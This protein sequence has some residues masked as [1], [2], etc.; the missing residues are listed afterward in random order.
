METAQREKTVVIRIGSSQPHF[1]YGNKYVQ[2]KP[3]AKDVPHQKNLSAYPGKIYVG[4]SSMTKG[5]YETGDKHRGAIAS[6]NA[7]DVYRMEDYGKV[8]IDDDTDVLFER[9]AP[10]RD[11]QGS[12]SDRIRAQ[13]LAKTVGGPGNNMWSACITAAVADGHG[14]L[15]CLGNQWFVGGFES[16]RIAAS[17]AAD[18]MSRFF[19]MEPTKQDKNGRYSEPMSIMSATLF[20]YLSNGKTPM[21]EMRKGMCDSIVNV[22]AKIF[23]E[24]DERIH[25]AWASKSGDLNID[26][27]F[28]QWR[29][30]K[31]G[32]A[33]GYEDEEFFGDERKGNGLSEDGAENH[34]V[35]IKKTPNGYVYRDGNCVSADFGCT[36]TTCTLLCESGRL[37]CIIAS[38]VG[39]S[40]ACRF[41]IKDNKFV[42]SWL[43]EDHGTENSKEVRRLAKYGTNVHPQT[44]YFSFERKNKMGHCLLMPSRGLGHP[45]VDPDQTGLTAKPSVKA[46]MIYP[47]EFVLVASDGLWTMANMTRDDCAKYLCHD[48]AGQCFQLIQKNV[49]EQ[50]KTPSQVCDEIAHLVCKWVVEKIRTLS[51]EYKNHIPMDNMTVVAMLCTTSS[52]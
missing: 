29:Q 2:Q 10:L 45:S 3:I 16:A 49:Q 7:K 31:A 26:A 47:G 43:T 22:C 37:A 4:P 21:E 46:E 6:R 5:E 1:V 17:S 18:K 15:P 27:P 25:S 20:Q 30:T 12:I 39:D 41:S 42:Y 34:F 28:W 8:V 36:L 13:S 9:T 11:G 23:E 14:S 24:C 38:S 50:D 52:Y 48:V 33:W 35:A 44:P 51:Q 32:K 40:S 19:N